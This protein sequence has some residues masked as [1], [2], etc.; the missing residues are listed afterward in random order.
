M[1]KLITFT[2]AVLIG[3]FMVAGVQAQNEHPASKEHPSAKTK[4]Q[5]SPAMEASGKIGT[6]NIT[7]NY[8][9][10]GVKGRTIW[11]ELVPFNEVWRAGA[12]EATTVKTDKDLLI[13]GKELPAGTYSFYV[14]PRDNGPST[15]IFNKV[16]KQWGGFDYDESKDAL[17]VDVSPVENKMT[18]RLE[19]QVNKDGIVL[20][21]ENWKLPI[22]VKVK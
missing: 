15:V 14:I 5:A 13:D 7:I 9:S 21:W 12:N 20:A 2:L 22:K 19:Y 18:E 1:K 17:R 11:G 4:A 6:A 3:L 8:S 10:P 16:A